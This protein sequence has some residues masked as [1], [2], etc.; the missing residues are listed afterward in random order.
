M[1]SKTSSASTSSRFD[2]PFHALIVDDGS[3]DGTAAAVK[4]KQ[5]EHADR[6]RLLERS[7]KLGLGTAYIAGFKWALEHGYE[8][9]Y[10][11]DCDFSHNPQD[12]PRLRKPA[13]TGRM[14]PSAR[15]PRGGKVSGWPV[16]RIP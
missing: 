10:E 13:S 3:P 15:A 5:A 4:A 1:R 6:I 7:G 12:L 8:L 9:I 11:M 16:G 14:L 2:T